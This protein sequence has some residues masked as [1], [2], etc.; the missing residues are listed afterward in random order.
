MD[1]CQRGEPPVLRN[2]DGRRVAC[3]LYGEVQQ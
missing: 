2:S 3:H 1:Q